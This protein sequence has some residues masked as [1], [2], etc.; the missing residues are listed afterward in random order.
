MEL[1]SEQMKLQAE[2][3][4]LPKQESKAYVK[5]RVSWEDVSGDNISLNVKVFNYHCIYMIT[6]TIYHYAHVHQS[7]PV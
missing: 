6:R 3:K 2:R 1:Y 4:P 7:P 5:I